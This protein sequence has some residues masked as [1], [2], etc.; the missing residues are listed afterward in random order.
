MSN[1]G[2][3]N[4]KVRIERAIFHVRKVKVANAIALA[5]AKALEYGNAKY[6]L[7]RVEYK[8][9]S[10]PSG[11]H[12]VIQEKKFTGQ[13]PTRVVVGC[14]DNDAFNGAYKKN[15]FNFQN[16]KITCVSRLVDG[17]AKCLLTCD[18]EPGRIAQAYMSLFFIY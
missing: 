11:G 3:N 5:H 9:L 14:V 4:Y 12:Y 18:F 16:Y 15:P 17:E 1:E 2:G 10:D 8:T 6:P 7:Q 13:L